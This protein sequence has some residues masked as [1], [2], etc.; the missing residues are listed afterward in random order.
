MNAIELV[1]LRKEFGSRT[2]V[3]INELD[4]FQ[5]DVFGFIGP[6][7]SGKTTTIRMIAGLLQPTNGEARI[8]GFSAQK[9]PQEIKKR[10]GYM[11]DYFGVYPG[12]KVWE[13]LDFFSACYYINESRRDL[14]IDNLLDLVEL[15]HR[16]DDLVD[17]LSHGL[18]QRLSLARTL[19]N[20]PQVLILD[21]PASGLDPRAR[22]E[23]RALLVEMSKM[24]KT[25]FFSTNILSDVA[26]I[27]TRVGIIEEGSLTRVARMEELNYQ[28]LNRRRVQILIL[29]HFREATILLEQIPGV[30]ITDTL[31]ATNRGARSR[32]DFEFEG[33][34]Q[35]LSL[36]LKQLIQSQIPV[37]HF[38][39][40]DNNL[41]EI[42]IRETKGVIP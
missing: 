19:I 37:L 36:L 38:I 1:D 11:P 27:C 17:Q 25:V 14:L 41:E 18:K 16:R 9:S 12:L 30:K 21:E 42:F 31:D 28:I 20:D 3:D 4:V 2:A 15:S 5:G 29:D 6:N 8:L 40:R 24:G 10:I 7:G 26:E 33:D 34:D 23:I 39:E 22:I 32:I 13:Y 35:S